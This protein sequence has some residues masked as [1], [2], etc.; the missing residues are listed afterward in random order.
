M[1]MLKRH[2]FHHLGL[3]AINVAIVALAMIDFY[4][5]IGVMIGSV[6]SAIVSAFRNHR[7]QLR[8]TAEIDALDERLSTAI[9]SVRQ[10]TAQARRDTGEKQRW[11]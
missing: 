2:L 11:S 8:R 4:L 1:T 7:R 3:A 5:G 6:L 10:A 9:A